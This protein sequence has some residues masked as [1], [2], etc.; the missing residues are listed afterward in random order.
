MKIIICDRCKGEGFTVMKGEL[1]DYHNGIS[2][3][4]QEVKCIKCAGTGR[5]RKKI[6]YEQL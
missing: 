1:I 3:P 4:D 2:E 5:L 6:F